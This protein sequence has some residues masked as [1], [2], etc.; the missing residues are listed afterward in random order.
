MVSHHT[1]PLEWIIEPLRST[2]SRSKCHATQLN[3]K[4]N[5]MIKYQQSLGIAVM[6]LFCEVKTAIFLD[7]NLADK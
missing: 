5:K 2:C 6:S 4:P 1:C 7:L 3:I